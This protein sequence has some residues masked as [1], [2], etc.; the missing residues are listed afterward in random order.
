MKKNLWLLLLVPV[1]LM[2]QTV[3]RSPAFY[4][5]VRTAAGGGGP[6][7]LINEGFEETDTGGGAGSSTDGYDSALF[8]DET[9]NPNQDNTTSPLVG[10][11]DLYCDTTGPAN[12][13]SRFTLGSTQTELH[14]YFQF[15]DSTLPANANDTITE[16]Q[17]NGNNS[18]MYLYLLTDGRLQIFNGGTSSATTDSLASG[19]L[20][21]IWV[22]WKTDGSAAVE[23]ATSA[24]KV[25]S[26]NKYASVTGGSGT[27]ACNKIWVGAKTGTA[28]QAHIDHMLVDDVA[29]GSNP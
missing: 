5:A 22:D 29:I 11:Q 16:F 17:D 8:T 26:G 10:A 4:G 2:A 21:H 9:G 27:A 25:G 18:Q 6:S 28:L 14:E 1:C 15:K 7:Y 23:F 19:T 13:F 20:Y 12:A 3:A 24:T